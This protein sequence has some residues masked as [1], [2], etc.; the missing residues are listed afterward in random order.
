LPRWFQPP[1]LTPQADLKGDGPW[2]V[3]AYFTG[4]QMV[5]DLASWTEPWEVHSDQGY[6]VVGVDRTGYRRLLEAGFRVEVDAQLTAEL[7]RPRLRL[8]GQTAA[9]PGFPCYRTVEE[10]YATAT[11]IVT[12]HPTLASWIDIGDT[13]EKITVTQPI[14]QD[15]P[16]YDLMVLRLTNAAVPGPKPKL[17]VMSSM[18]AREYPPAELNTRFAEYLV[19][20]YDVDPDVTWLLDYHEIHLLLQA[21]PDGRKLAEGG[22]PQRKN[23]NNSNGGGCNVPPQEN[24]QYGTDLNRNFEFYWNGCSVGGCSSDAPCAWNYRG[25]SA[26]SEPETQA[27]QEYLR[28]QFPDLR[29]APLTAAV[30]IT[31]AG[32][33]IDLHNKAREV[34]WPWGFTGAVAPN[35]AA[36][37]TLGRKLA[38]FNLY[39]PEQSFTMYPADG[40]SHDFAYGE[41][42]LAAY[43]IELGETDFFQD[44]DTFDNTILP[45]NLPALLYAAKV[46]RAPYLTPAGPDALSVSVSPTLVAAGA[47]VT[48][49]AILTDARYSAL[50]GTEPSQNIV[51]AE[52][53][54]DAPPW[55]TTTTPISYPLAAADGA[56]DAPQEAVQ[57]TLDTGDLTEGRHMLFVRGQDAA[58]NWGPFSAVFIHVSLKPTAQFTAAAPIQVSQPVTFTNLSA[59]TLPIT[60]AWDFGD[61]TPP[62]YQ[63]TNL[64][65]THTY[66]ASGQFTV[67]LTATNS[68]GR[69][70]VSHTVT[71]LPPPCPPVTITH[72]TSNAPVMLGEAVYLSAAVAGQPP[73]SY[74]WSFGDGQ[75]SAVTSQ[76]SATHTYTAAG[77]YTVTLEIANQCAASDTH[78]ISLTV[79]SLP[80]P[81]PTW[82]TQVYVNDVL[83]DALSIQVSQGDAVQIVDQVRITA[84]HNVTYSLLALWTDSLTLSG[85]LSSTGQITVTSGAAQWDVQDGLPH[86]GYAL[87]KT[88]QV[89]DGEW[90]YDYLTQTLWIWQAETQPAPRILIFDNQVTCSAPFILDLRSDAP[91]QMGKPMHLTATVVG[92]GPLTYTWEWG[93]H[94]PSQIGAE[95]SAVSHTYALSGAYPVSLTVVNVCPESD[96]QT[97]WVQVTPR[98][99]LYLPLM[100]KP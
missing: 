10:T 26:A 33:F 27:I 24:N 14:T 35:G 22:D 11:A 34:L 16:G 39:T 82:I 63:F 40:V 75:P 42:G 91:V 38:Y 28:A 47:P 19:D 83:T 85:W 6:V 61:A 78:A 12:A 76:P 23:T 29:A 8:P 41:L 1:P 55:V 87:T 49:T 99:D 94:S 88:F 68:M 20:Q 59:G 4:R 64:P 84:V 3:R 36:L 50:N 53:Y 48:L 25:P 95:L 44:C 17:F 18:H 66:T 52:Y 57:A 100:I 2:V 71:V 67:T 56:F 37:Q 89:G 80:P 90:A 43:T 72:L 15:L 77:S 21:N 5:N 13:W 86:T 98:Y 62:I 69:D 92:D 97:L 93:D 70:S 74:T 45:D 46:V 32:L 51:A 31:A 60:Y 9:I 54:V 30:P 58:G 65:T 81:Q 7:N 73:L 96:Q 79:N